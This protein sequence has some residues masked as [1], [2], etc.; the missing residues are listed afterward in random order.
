MSHLHKIL[1]LFCFCILKPC[2]A[3][4]HFLEGLT[5]LEID[6][7]NLGYNISSFKNEMPHR[8]TLGLVYNP[9]HTA[10]DT[11]IFNVDFEDYFNRLLYQDYYYNETYDYIKVNFQQID[12]QQSLEKNTL[13]T[14]IKVD[15]AYQRKTTQGYSEKQLISTQDTVFS[16]S[17]KA[18][19]EQ[20]S[21]AIENNLL[22]F[23]NLD[24]NFEN[25]EYKK[26]LQKKMENSKKNSLRAASFFLH[27]HIGMY[28]ASTYLC[29]AN[30]KLRDTHGVYWFNS[31]GL[32]KYYPNILESKNIL[33]SSYAA[34]FYLMGIAYHKK[35][36]SQK[37]Y[38][39]F[40]ILAQL[41]VESFTYQPPDTA[42]TYRVH[43]VYMGLEA[44]QTLDFFIDS[45]KTWILGAGLFE[46]FYINTQKIYDL[47]LKI[48]LGY[49]FK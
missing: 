12:I 26:M 28:S 14:I 30:A 20:I 5:F 15:I 19:E 39:H 48:S 23:N 35:L 21:Y 7:S 49:H 37:T 3:Q 18:L 29:Y 42:T 45:K 34:P 33:S 16:T 24:R 1:F 8:D 43:N 6:P 4:V 41:G 25:E 22:K 31:I 13:K 38:L 36:N 2:V 40:D 17:N 44:S 32:R 27:N 10:K 9:K 46:G 47:G 11:L